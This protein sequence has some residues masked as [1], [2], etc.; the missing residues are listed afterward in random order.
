[1]LSL[2]AITGTVALL[3]ALTPQATDRRVDIGG[4]SL[5]ARLLGTAGPT[6][7]LEASLGSALETWDPIIKPLAGFAR[8]IAYD[9]AG[10]GKSEPGPL[11]RS[12]RQLAR[13]LHALL[14]AVD[15]EPPFVLV[16]HSAAGFA[17]RIFAAQH[18]EEVAAML[19]IDVTPERLGAA[20]NAIAPEA[21]AEDLA[22]TD[23]HY[24]EAPES[25]PIAAAWEAAHQEWLGIR[26]A[27]DAD[28]GSRI[29]ELPAALPDVPVV[30][31]TAIQ[32]PDEPQGLT[33]TPEGAEAWYALH[34]AWVAPLGNAVQVV[35]R[36]AGHFIHEDRPELVLRALREI[37]RVLREGGPLSA[38]A[39]RKSRPSPALPTRGG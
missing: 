4:H 18:P 17:L 29:E 34:A 6:V 16:G 2:P 9:R 19:L 22:R 12:P 11:P 15:A 23:A 30:V 26:A 33:Q 7:V 27:V 37:T 36:D 21:W 38:E 32:L 5:R 24:A 20:M 28:D 10:L 14:D 1:M 31:L 13:E 8:V 3:L 39:I 25:S 35:T